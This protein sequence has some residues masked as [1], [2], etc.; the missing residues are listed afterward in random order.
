MALALQAAILLRA[1][2]E[3][4]SLAP[5]AKAFCRSRLDPGHGLAFGTLKHD[6]DFRA[7]LSRVLP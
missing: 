3:D 7:I 5:V 6:V 1:A 4:A 2:G